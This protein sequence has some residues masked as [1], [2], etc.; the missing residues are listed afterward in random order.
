MTGPSP[1]FEGVAHRVA[2]LAEVAADAAAVRTEARTVTRGELAALAGGL[3]DRLADTGADGT[4]LCLARDAIDLAVVTL[5][6]DGL[7]RAVVIGSIDA[8]PSA[9]RALV[10]AAGVTVASGPMDAPDVPGLG[11]T[12]RIGQ[13]RDWTPQ[14]RPASDVVAFVS[15]SGSMG[16]P[17]LVGL[18]QERF[19]D[20]SHEASV[21]RD[22]HA[23]D[24]VATTLSTASAPFGIIVRTLMAGAA[25]SVLDLRRMP[26]SRVMQL[27]AEH[28]VSRVRMV[29]SVLRRLATATRAERA[30]AQVLERVT[31][32]GSIGEA[33]HWQDV[34]LLRRIV[35]D[36]ALLSNTYGLTE[37]G[38]LT[39]RLIRNEEPIG[40]GPVD[41]GHPLRGRRLWIDAGHGVRAGVGEIGEIVVEGHLGSIGVPME[42]LP[43][44]EQ[45][46]CTGDAGRVDAQGRFHHCGRRDR[47]VKVGGMRVDLSAVEAVFRDIS[48]V[49][50]VAVSEV[51]VEGPTGQ[52][53]I[54]LAADVWAI[55]S[56]SASDLRI[57]LRE[58]L[59]AAATPPILRLHAGPLPTL[60]SGKIDLQR[61]RSTTPSDSD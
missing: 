18:L 12:V 41:I 53:E 57:S 56:L 38:V 14:P 30:P 15:T 9:L 34:A 43:S 40:E 13:H 42:D 8:D 24:R 52:A 27:V 19:G 50:E 59:G 6:A 5:A 39:E 35:P 20:H 58:R 47:V 49:L 3:A 2:R 21:L 25:C 1:A 7:G 36:T 10:N 4:V 46:F 29:T 45:R 22:L 23:D 54:R 33:L 51:S 31:V 26:P 60:L 44:G 28:E 48:G 32:L 17:R 16:S 11:P 37:T 61:L 55:E